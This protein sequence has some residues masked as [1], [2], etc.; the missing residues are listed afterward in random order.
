MLN[1]GRKKRSQVSKE[2][3][4]AE[5]LL[6]YRTYLFHVDSTL[7][8]KFVYPSFTVTLSFFLPENKLLSNSH[9][10]LVPIDDEDV[11]MYESVC[12]DKPIHRMHQHT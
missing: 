9:T 8:K 11:N 4:D 5:F 1:R 12:I 3:H 6:N 7:P 10:Q 2:K